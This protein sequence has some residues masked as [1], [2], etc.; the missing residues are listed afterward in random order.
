MCSKSEDQ[1][2]CMVCTYQVALDVRSRLGRGRLARPLRG[3]AKYKA[4]LE[5]QRSVVGG[6][7]GV[8][9]LTL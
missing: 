1:L 7:E 6:A 5:L 8:R 9:T 2:C 4:M 3:Q